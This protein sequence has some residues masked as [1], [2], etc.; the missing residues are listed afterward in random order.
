M[1]DNIKEKLK[2]RIAISKMDSTEDEKTNKIAS[3]I[4]LCIDLKQKTII[5]YL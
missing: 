4:K 1:N 2:F 5:L 3:V